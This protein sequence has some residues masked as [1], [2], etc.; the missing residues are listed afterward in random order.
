MHLKDM[1]VI[2]EPV[3]GYLDHITMA[4]SYGML[5]PGIGKVDICLQNHRADYSH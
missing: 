4:R 2:V 1:N 5:K 3:A